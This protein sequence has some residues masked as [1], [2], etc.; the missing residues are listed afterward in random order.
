MNPPLQQNQRTLNKLLSKYT[1]DRTAC[2]PSL[3]RI[4]LDTAHLL[5]VKVRW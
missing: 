3:T 4:G 5:G 2:C 1:G